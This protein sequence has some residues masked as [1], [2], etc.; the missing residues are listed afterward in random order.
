MTT[1]TKDAVSKNPSTSYKKC[2]CK[3]RLNT[4]CASEKVVI[5]GRLIYINPVSNKNRHPDLININALVHS[6]DSIQKDQDNQSKMDP[7]REKLITQIIQK[8]PPLKN[9]TN[10]FKK[11]MLWLK[12]VIYPQ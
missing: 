2:R 6:Q 10:L 3:K 12:Q 5:K 7:V 1:K 11:M 4:V 8:D 9:K